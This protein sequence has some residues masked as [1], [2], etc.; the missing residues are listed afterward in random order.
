MKSMTQPSFC[1]MFAV[2]H[3][4]SSLFTAPRIPFKLKIDSYVGVIITG[5]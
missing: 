3:N 4:V 2:T 5:N 1:I